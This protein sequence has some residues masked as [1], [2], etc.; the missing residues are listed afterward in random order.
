MNANF[1]KKVFYNRKSRRGFKFPKRP[2][3]R[4]YIKNNLKRRI[5]YNFNSKIQTYGPNSTVI[6]LS[7]LLNWEMGEG[8]YNYTDIVAGT[9]AHSDEYKKFKNDFQFIKILGIGVTIY[10]NDALNN[11]PTYIDL[12]WTGAQLAWE[13][14]VGSDKA[15][16]I[17]NDAKKQKTFYYRPPDV[18]TTD[19]FNPRRFNL[20]QNFEYSSIILSC[21]QNGGS[22][23]GRV[24]MRVCF[25]GPVTPSSRVIFEPLIKKKIEKE[26]S[27]EEIINNKNEEKKNKRKINLK[28]NKENNV[29]NLSFL[30]GLV[31]EGVSREEI[32]NSKNYDKLRKRDKEKIKKL[33]N[34]RKN[35]KSVIDYLEKNKK[36]KMQNKKEIRKSNKLW[37]R[38]QKR[39]EKIEEEE[40]QK[41][42]VLSKI[43]DSKSFNSDEDV[44]LDEDDKEII[45]GFKGQSFPD[46][47]RVEIIYKKQLENDERILKE[48]EDKNDIADYKKDIKRINIILNEI[49]KEKEIARLSDEKK[50]NEKNKKDVSD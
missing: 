43:I 22:F 5:N 45:C 44:I 40:K 19:N 39:K 21:V 37:K 49:K 32:L 6:N 14:I 23:K 9:V 36:K 2:F 29:T 7:G 41:N 13:D 1:L 12:D 16:I 33:L 50:R 30:S 38:E 35:N 34:M 20:I 27:Q 8:N 18:I 3:R 11:E 28:K 47:Q 25:R 10:P 42:L 46:L 15:K 4:N 26:E 31:A 17:Y 48:T 24:D